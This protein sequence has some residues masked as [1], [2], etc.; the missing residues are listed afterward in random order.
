MTEPVKRTLQRQLSKHPQKRFSGSRRGH[1]GEA[2]CFVRRA[3]EITLTNS[4]GATVEMACL[5]PR[6]LIEVRS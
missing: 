5:R 6:V 3:C 2:E 1:V 4:N